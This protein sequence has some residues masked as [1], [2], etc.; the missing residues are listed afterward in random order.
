MFNKE[1]GKHTFSLFLVLVAKRKKMFHQQQ[2][3]CRF[4]LPLNNL[5]DSMS[6]KRE[7][8]FLY[9]EKKVLKV[10]KNIYT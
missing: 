1:T 8:S 7:K 3:F 6:S 2:I 10:K 9:F 4:E 5:L